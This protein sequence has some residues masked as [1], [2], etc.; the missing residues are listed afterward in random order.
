MRMNGGWESSWTDVLMHGEVWKSVDLAV[1][2]ATNLSAHGR[3]V[4]LS[5]VAVIAQ[6]VQL[7]V[8]SAQVSTPSLLDTD[9]FPKR[10]LGTV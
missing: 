6:A 8:I 2:F 3:R 1:H 7:I 4:R 9:E 10:S 5:G